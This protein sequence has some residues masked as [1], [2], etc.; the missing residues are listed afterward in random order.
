RATF[1]TR[2]VLCAPTEKNDLR[3]SPS[4]LRRD[5]PFDRRRRH[6][7][8]LPRRRIDTHAG[9][10]DLP[11]AAHAACLAPPHDP[12]APRPRRTRSN[13]ALPRSVRRDVPP[14]LRGGRVR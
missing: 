12:L 10:H 11:L 9:I 6:L 1:C 7:P 3:S 8:P 4:G 14:A 13:P 2:E 5:P